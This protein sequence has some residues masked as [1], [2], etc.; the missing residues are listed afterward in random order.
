MPYL[1]RARHLRRSRAHHGVRILDRNPSGAAATSTAYCAPLEVL[2]KAA[3]TSPPSGPT[4]EENR[5]SLTK[6]ADSVVAAASAAG[7]TNVSDAFR[8]FVESADPLHSRKEFEA[9]VS[10]AG[11]GILKDCGINLEKK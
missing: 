1:G 10:K 5:R 4:K 6:L 2:L 9:A 11:A 7:K 8:L 3:E